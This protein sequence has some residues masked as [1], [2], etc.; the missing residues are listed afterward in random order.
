MASQVGYYQIIRKYGT[1]KVTT[2]MLA[3]DTRTNTQ[4]FLKV[5]KASPSQFNLRY[6]MQTEFEVLSGLNHPNIV[7]I[8]E[9]NQNTAYVSKSGR[10]FDVSCVAMELLPKGTYSTICSM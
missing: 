5:L 9:F 8:V 7:R 3:V 6:R 10:R 1:S 2:L 4:V